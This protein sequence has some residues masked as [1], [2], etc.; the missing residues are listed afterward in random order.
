MIQMARNMANKKR[1]IINLTP[2]PPK[3]DDPEAFVID[4][5]LSLDKRLPAKAGFLYTKLVATI[6]VDDLDRNELRLT[7]KELKDLAESGQE[8][9]IR[10][11][12]LLAEI[13]HIRVVTEELE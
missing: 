6:S 4:M 11:L 5:R 9:A 3:S 10:H 13:G 8:S 12:E 2:P 1:Y 7:P